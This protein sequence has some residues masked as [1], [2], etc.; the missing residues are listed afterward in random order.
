MSDKDARKPEAEGPA[1][2]LGEVVEEYIPG[3]AE[4]VVADPS[5]RHEVMLRMDDHDVRMLLERAQ[6]TALKKW[7][8][9]LPDGTMGLT[10]G[11]VQDITQQM[12]WM[13][14]CRIGVL[15]ETLEVERIVEDAGHGEE[16]FWV[17]T[18]FSC[19]EVTGA[20]LP[21]SSMEPV[22]MRL[23][24]STADRKRQQGAKIPE[25]NTVFDP[26]SRTK[27]IQKATRNALAA[28]IPEEVEQAIIAM[29]ANDPARVERI[30]TEAEQKIEDRPAPLDDDEAKAKIVTARS[31]YDEIRELGGAAVTEFTPGKF[32]AYLLNAQHSHETLDAFLDYVRS[33]RDRLVEKYGGKA[34][35]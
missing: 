28:F 22:R 29:F 35:A 18:I 25:D 9:Q 10:V 3:P 7:V 12:N 21:G 4:L 14:K 19:D 33:E 23:R 6:K 27:A 30:R 1:P 2:E 5:D 16:P 26:F 13:G 15:P 34:A 17:A 24:K 11:A 32:G 8:Y 31:L 20:R